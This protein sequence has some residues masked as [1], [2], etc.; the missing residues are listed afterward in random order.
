MDKGQNLVWVDMEMT[1]LE[2]DKHRILEIAIVITN[3]D[4]KVLGKPVELVV[5]Q[6][7]TVLTKM[8]KWC[9]EN[10]D[11]DL[12]KK[13]SESKLTV[14]EAEKEIMKI[15]SKYC[16]VKKGLLAGNSIHNDRLF[17]DKY[18]PRITNYLHYRLIDVTT[19][20]ELTKRWRPELRG[21]VEKMK[22]D[23]KH[24]AMEDIMMSIAEL[25]FYRKV[26]FE[27]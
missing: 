17:L 7:K 10:L 8:N 23:K 5:H 27:K 4:L 22:E 1:G 12:L 14:R 20:K 18:M 13:V 25:R 9:R 16:D 15:I 21:V 26:I 11:P 3:S 19:L 6:P 24:R 2:P